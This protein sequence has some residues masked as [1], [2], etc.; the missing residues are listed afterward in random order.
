MI[1][2]YIGRPNL[3]FGDGKFSILD[4]FCFAEFLRCYHSLHFKSTENDYEPEILQDHLV[5]HNHVLGN[6][7]STQIPMISS[8]EKLKC[9]K[10]PYALKYYVPNKH[11]KPKG[12]AHHILSND[13]KFNN[14]YVEKLN[15][16]NV[17][18][19]INLNCMKV[20]PYTTL[21]EDALASLATN[22]EANL[23]PFG[24]YENDE[25]NDRLNEEL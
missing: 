11:T 12:Y 21:V 2:R 16:P 17:L 22:Q 20:E 6:N 25:V 1:D 10:V 24:Q 3:Y 9:R 14:R 5:E 23:D 18:K 19:I 4:S 7:Y 8:N 15:Q 13:S